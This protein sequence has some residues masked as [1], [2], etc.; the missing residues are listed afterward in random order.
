MK[1][2]E[3]LGK[4]ICDQW[5]TEIKMEGV[6]L[7][8]F[9]NMFST[10]RSITILLLYIW[11]SPLYVTRCYCPTRVANTI[12]TAQSP[13]LQQTVSLSSIQKCQRQTRKVIVLLLALFQL[14]IFNFLFGFIYDLIFYCLRQ[15]FGHTAICALCTELI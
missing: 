9:V 15:V 3:L 4:V 2:V 7:I 10:E 5:I 12:F 1:G 14:Y 6:F 13:K 8:A 11:Q